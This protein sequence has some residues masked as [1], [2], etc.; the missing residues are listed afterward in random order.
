MDALRHILKRHWGYDSFLPL[1]QEAMQCVMDARDSVVILP[2]GGGKSLCFQAP[3]MAMQGMALVISPLLS[4]MKD[5]VD[6]LRTNGIPAAKFD[7]SMTASEKRLVNQEVRER[8]LRL[9]YVS[10]ERVVQPAFSEYVR[11]TDIS[12]LVV[13]E[14][15]CISHWG[16]DFRPEYRELSRLRTAFPDKAIH[17]YTATA[18]EHV[19]EDI[20]REL[21][22]RSPTVLIGSYDRPNLIYR[23][24]R[25]TSGYDQV[26]SVIQEHAG[27]PGI[28][29]CIRRADVDALCERLSGAGFKALPYHA[30]MDDAS[31]KRNQEAFAKDDTDIIVATVAFGM[32]IDKSNVRYVLHAAMPKSLE[33]YHQE[34]G[35]AGRDGLPS[36]CCLLYSYADFKL[37]QGIIE[38]KEPEGAAVAR[39]KLGDMLRYCERAECRHKALVSYFG[40]QYP[41]RPC[42]ACDLCLGPAD[43]LENAASVSQAILLCVSELGP[44]AGPTYTTLVLTGSRE[45]RVLAKGHQRLSSHG[46]LAS[47]EPAIVRDWV[48]Q[49]VRQGFL[50]KT[51]E[52]NV[53]S[54]TQ[55]GCAARRGEETPQ[56]ARPS[57]P[58]SREKAQAGPFDRL[59]FD[60]LR[61]VR[62]RKAEELEVPPFVIFSDAALRDMARLK[63][64]DRAG[65]LAVHG[66]GERKC[67]A[68]ADEFLAAIREFCATNPN[69]ATAANGAT[70]D[71]DHSV[72]PIREHR[73]R[74]NRLQRAAALLAQ[75]QSI[76]QVAETL[77]RKPSTVAQYLVE[78]IQ[79]GG[80]TDPTPWV[81]PSVFARIREAV[82]AVGAERLSPIYEH[83]NREVGYGEIRICMACIRNLRR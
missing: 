58:R 46:A 64:S 81:T 16:H 19:R 51:G 22:L 59:L 50:E 78:Y 60:E 17:A 18:T 62:R 26:R 41:Q 37:W 21:C 36:D 28:V 40:E 5:Q 65:F 6:A 75:G 14:A 42:G 54:L 30:G 70:A 56:L 29:Y 68:F 35:R 31:R 8:K 11:E 47:S 77:G 34:T 52:Y 71:L 10:P 82:A 20:V 66:V 61:R 23:V 57:P 74:S 49:L 43:V 79:Q 2:T 27:E 53:L 15:H 55:R 24:E 4:L 76:G 39:T 9:L 83:L 67:E 38:K 73:S 13:D 32:G 3:A 63:P 44:L 1:Q 33:H 7:S 12:F 80:I 45:E 48:E 25:R 72:G 69:A